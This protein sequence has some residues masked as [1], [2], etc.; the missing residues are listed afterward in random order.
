MKINIITAVAALV[1]A[2]TLSARAQGTTPTPNFLNVDLGPDNGF[3][4][5][6]GKVKVV[7]RQGDLT[8]LSPAVASA[9]LAQVTGGHQVAHTT[10]APAATPC[11][12]RSP[13]VLGG[14][15]G[16]A[17]GQ[18]VVV[19][20]NGTHVSNLATNCRT[21][22]VGA[23]GNPAMNVV[24]APLRIIGGTAEILGG[25]GCNNRDLVSVVG[26]PLM[27]VGR[28]PFQMLSG[29]TGAVASR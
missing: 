29:V 14:P 26:E 8:L 12:G 19:A 7:Q 28:A 18:T 13:A 11:G 21:D 15:A 25:G 6:G 23:I 1:T 16:Q 17:V 20:G 5:E 10:P 9:N 3:V 27:D 24:R 4:V 22:V 2:F